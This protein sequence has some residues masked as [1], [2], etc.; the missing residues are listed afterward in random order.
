VCHLPK[1]IDTEKIEKDF[2]TIHEPIHGVHGINWGIY[3]TEGCLV[4][5]CHW[6][7]AHMARTMKDIRT[8]LVDNGIHK[9]AFSVSY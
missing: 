4:I 8:V 2:I 3:D 9:A 6:D 5:Q 1:D 7:F